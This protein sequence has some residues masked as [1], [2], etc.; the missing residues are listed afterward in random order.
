[1]DFE[2]YSYFVYLNNLSII[3]IYKLKE[4][5]NITTNAKQCNNE[6]IHS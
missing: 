1:M 2:A 4:S 5:I 6:K 3:D